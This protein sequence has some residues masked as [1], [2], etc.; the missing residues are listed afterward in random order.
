MNSS[1][2]EDQVGFLAGEFQRNVT[3]TTE[4]DAEAKLEEAVLVREVESDAATESRPPVVAILGHVD[5]GKTSLLDK[6]RNANVAEKEHGGITQ[7]IGAFQVETKDGQP[8]T[9]LD[10]PGHAAFTSMR[11]RGANVADIVVLVVAA[12]DGVMPQ[13]EE[14]I[15]HAKVAGVPIVVAVNKIDKS[16]ANPTKVKQQ[17]SAHGLLTEEWGGETLAYDLSAIT[18]D[19]IDDLVEGLAL[20]AEMAE[21][22]A[23]PSLPARGHVIEARKDPAK[24]VI[25]T[26]LVEEGTLRRGDR[27][28][29]GLGMGRIRRLQ[30]HNG[31]VI[32]EATPSTPVEVFGLHTPPDAGDTFLVINDKDL[33]KQ[34]LEERRRRERDATVRDRPQVTLAT[35]FGQEGAEDVKELN[36]ILKADVKG[37]LEPLRNEIAK[38][39]HPEVKVNLLYSTLG[40]VSKSDVDNAVI[41]NGVIIGFH[42]M[43][44]PAAKKEAERKGVEIRQYMVIYEVVDDI[45]AAMENMLTP[46]QREE[47]TG[48][49]EIRAIFSSSKL[50]NLAGCYVT[51]GVIMR[52]GFIR[53]YREGKLIY[54]ADRPMSIDSLKRFKDDAKE[55]REGF[56]CGVRIQGYQDI[57]EGDVLEF[58]ALRAVKRSLDS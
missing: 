52:D 44:E 49:A 1:L 3:I 47:V 19:G 22:N 51:D 5:H 37:S 6:I 45:K 56:E 16:N 40:A 32:S 23:H 35:I 58:Y 46:E 2:D 30:D 38:L 26:L 12:D 33:A 13:T 29:A 11:A 15:N 8:V 20:Q 50:G 9:F 55:V 24:G 31:A 34:T 4:K 7:H 41:A 17:L 43:P 27:V 10:T 42:V 48:H 18:G 25:C 54:G 36:I 28:I 39:E 57:K 21:L 14:A 53:L